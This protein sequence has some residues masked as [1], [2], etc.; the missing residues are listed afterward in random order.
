M[1]RRAGSS[2]SGC[3]SA[4]SGSAEKCWGSVIMRT[5]RKVEEVNERCRA[6]AKHAPGIATRKSFDA[7]GGERVVAALRQEHEPDHAVVG[8]DGVVPR[9]RRVQLLQPGDHD[10]LNGGVAQGTH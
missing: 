4:S 1:R 5:R 2:S 6:K 9:K 7:C 10:H 8:R 3:T